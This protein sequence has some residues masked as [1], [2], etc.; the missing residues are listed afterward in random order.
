MY[1]VMYDD[2]NDALEREEGNIEGMRKRGQEA[3]ERKGRLG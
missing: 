3:R 2:R 1:I